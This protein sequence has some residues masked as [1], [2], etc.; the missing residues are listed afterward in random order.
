MT[1]WLI[2]YQNMTQHLRSGKTRIFLKGKI[3]KKVFFIFH[4]MRFMKF[5]ANLRFVILD[6]KN[7]FFNYLLILLEMIMS[8]YIDVSQ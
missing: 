3:T 6:I 8:K 2:D 5:L 1:N 7:F 4:C